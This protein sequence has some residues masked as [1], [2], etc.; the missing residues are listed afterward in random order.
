MLIIQIMKHTH[1]IVTTFLMTAFVLCS[2]QALN[3]TILN[4]SLTWSDPLLCM[5]ILLAV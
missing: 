1:S 2:N 3:S 5:V 4:S